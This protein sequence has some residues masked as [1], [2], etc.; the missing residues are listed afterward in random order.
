VSWQTGL[1]GRLNDPTL[2][3]TGTIDGLNCFIMNSNQSIRWLNGKNINDYRHSIDAWYATGWNT[4]GDNYKHDPFAT[5]CKLVNTPFP[6]RMTADEWSK[7]AVVVMDMWDRH[8]DKGASSR[9]Q[10]LAPEVEKFTRKARDKGALIIHS[11]STMGNLYLD[12]NRSTHNAIT[13]RKNAYAAR[14]DALPPDTW[15]RVQFYYLGLVRSGWDSRG[16][17]FDKIVYPAGDGPTTGHMTTNVGDPTRQ[18]PAISIDAKDAVSADEIAQCESYKEILALTQDRPYIIYVGVATNWCILRRFNGMRSMYK[19]G[20]SMWLVKD[21]TD[22]VA[23]DDTHGTVDGLTP[24]AAV[25]TQDQG[26]GRAPLQDYQQRKLALSHF[27]GTDLVVDWIGWNLPG[28]R[29]DTRDT[30][31]PELGRFRFADD[32]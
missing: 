7:T 13:A 21:L 16:S 12:P 10:E 9:L 28:T 30:E 20:K 25:L 19:A 11:P 18:H 23:G 31:F 29:T 24:V 14:M 1:K 2:K 15:E 3:V 26:P 6:A 27:R 8:P 4:N 17:F 5:V 22:A 32:K